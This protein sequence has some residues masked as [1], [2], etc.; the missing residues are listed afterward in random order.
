MSTTEITIEGKA[1]LATGA[2]RGLGK[3]LVDEA[4]RQGAQRVYAAARKPFSHSDG[5]IIPLIL[6]VTDSWMGP[7]PAHLGGSQCDSID[8]RPAVGP[9]ATICHH[10]IPLEG[11]V[12]DPGD[13]IDWAFAYGEPT[14][15]LGHERTQDE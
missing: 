3:A 2:N 6:D 12:T 11:F 10:T 4:L 5:R 8:M 7:S 15:R 14:S 9:V 1:V 13:S